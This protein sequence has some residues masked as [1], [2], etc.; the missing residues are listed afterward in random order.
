MKSI[1]PQFILVVACVNSKECKGAS[2]IL[3]E[4]L[5]GIPH[6]KYEGHGSFTD[7]TCYILKNSA[8]FHN[9]LDNIDSDKCTRRFMAYAP[10]EH[11]RTKLGVNV[12]QKYSFSSTSNM[13]FLPI[14][15]GIADSE[16]DKLIAITRG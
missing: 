15:L 13:L 16:L 14:R 7:T 5:E 10:Y 4:Y 3:A 1:P 9:I 12:Y 6:I 2:E 11:L 8:G